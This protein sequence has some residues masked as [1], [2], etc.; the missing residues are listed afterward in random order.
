MNYICLDKENFDEILK[1]ENVVVDFYAS[2]CG[3]CKMFAP[4][5]EEV[6]KEKQRNAKI[7]IMESAAE[8]YIVDRKSL[9]TSSSCYVK[10]D[11]LI[12]STLINADDK[13]DPTTNSDFGGCILYNKLEGTYSY[14][15]TCGTNYCIS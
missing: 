5:F 12:S 9:I 7:K 1:K 8:I 11:E 10:I 14:Q 2:W 6:S 15:D 3:P 13:I 4:I